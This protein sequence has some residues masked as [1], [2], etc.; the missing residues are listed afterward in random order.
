MR[1]VFR[2]AMVIMLALLSV[3]VGGFVALVLW[4]LPGLRLLPKAR[5]IALDDVTTIE[6]AIAACQQ[7]GL[8]GWALVAYA[9]QLAAR[10]FSYSRRNPWDSSARAF[11]RGMGYCQQQALALQRIYIGLGIGAQPVYALQCQFPPTTIHGMPEPE[12]VSPH[13]WLRVRIGKEVRDVCCGSRNNTPGLVHFTVLSDVKP[14]MPWLRPFSH[15]GSV[16]E[17]IRRDRRARQNQEMPARNGA[18]AA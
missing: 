7:S 8:I 14:L 12:R 2:G 17:N 18:R 16:I 15:L 10:K 11:A 4:S 9:Q 1:S 13:T 3:V 5:R 6:D